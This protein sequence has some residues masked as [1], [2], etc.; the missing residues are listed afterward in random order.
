MAAYY[1]EEA[2]KCLGESREAAINAAR[3]TVAQ[4]RWAL[5]LGP[6]TGY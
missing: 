1:A 2:R 3:A 4:N 6:P 5:V